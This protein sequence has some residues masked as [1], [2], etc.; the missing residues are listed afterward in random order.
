MPESYAELL[1]QARAEV[2]EVTTAEAADRLRAGGA[3]LVD[4]REQ[5]EWDAGHLPG[6]I[7]VPKSRLEASIDAAV[8]DRAAP[9]ILYC[10]VGQRSL[11]AAQTMRTLGY[12]DVASMAGGIEQWAREG[13]EVV[14]PGGLTDAAA[15]ALQPP[16]ADPRGG[17]GRPGAAARLEGPAR[18]RGRAGLARGAVPRGRRRR[19]PRDRRL[20]RRRR[21]EPPAPGAPLDGACRHAQDRVGRADDRCAEPRRPCRR[22]R[23]DAGRGQRR[24]A[25]R[26]LRRGARRDGHLRDPVPAQRRRRHRRD[27]GRPRVR[28]PVRGP[29]HG[30]RPAGRVPATGASTRPRRRP[31]SRRPAPWPGC[32]AWCPGSWACSRR[33]RCSSCSWASG[34]RSPAGSSCSTP[35]RASSRSCGSAA[36]RRAPCAR[37]R[38]SRRGRRA[39]RSRCRCRRR[40]TTAAC[41]RS[42]LPVPR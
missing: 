26:G 2:P 28:V 20:R 24:A 8:P 33:T 42:A 27:P 16:S 18:G 21:V 22:A 41:S 14:D 6:A 38:R 30:L 29:A 11:F 5:L 35:S 7:L 1:R 39:R 34:R 15:P 3:L 23:R 36:T 12:A 37:R 9:V 25:H 40:P 10:G 4:V 13:R 19:H 17:P 32:W 31:S